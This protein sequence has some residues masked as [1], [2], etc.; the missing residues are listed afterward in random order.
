MALSGPRVLGL[1]LAGGRSTRFGSEKA[2]APV[3]GAPMV[4]RVAAVLARGCEALAVNARADSGA[5]AWARGAGLE[6]LPDPPGAPD[7]PLAGVLAGLELA[8]RH[9]AA[10][11]LTAPCDTP[12]LPDDF[13][14]R[15]MAEVRASAA[16]T[17]VTAEGSHPLC[18]LWSVRLRDRLAAAL[19]DG[20][21]PS[22]RAWLR[23]AGAAEVRFAEAQA[24]ANVNTSAVLTV[25]G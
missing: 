24:F 10:W 22:V 23:E 9:G 13:A 7:G 16:A 20:A 17:A 14:A 2:V 25:A 4:A 1:V 19:K 12:W 6:T 11:L 3:E 21:H 15:L 18:T 5:A 8:E